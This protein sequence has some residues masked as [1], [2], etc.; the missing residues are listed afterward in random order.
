MINP[1]ITRSVSILSILIQVCALGFLCPLVSSSSPL[2]SPSPRD[3][4][5]QGR[6]AFVS[7]RSG[8]N[9]IY[10]MRP[11][12]TD[13]VNLT[14]HPA[15]DRLP[16]WSPDGSKIAFR[17]T[18]NGNSEIYVMNDDGSGVIRLTFDPA[19]D[20]SPAWT[21]EG[22]VLFSSNR[23]GRF[24]IYSVK[25][26]GSDLRHID[27]AVDGDLTF[28][29]AS[30]SG[31][32]LAFATT[33]FFDTGAIWI[34]HPDGSHEKQLTDDELVAAFPDWSPTGNRVVFSNNVCPV[35]DL[36]EI[37]VVNQGGNNLRQLT[38]SGD[39]F[40]DLFPRWS[41]DGTQI[42]FSRDD[43]VEATEIY[44]MNADGTGVTNIT[45]HPSFDFE[46][47]WGP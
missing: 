8:N 38:P 40:N 34:A 32:R 28:P 6:I 43:F 19:V 44:I 27:I 21:P 22:L 33:N 45:Q 39:G 29:S 31:H 30:A 12:G 17:S 9:D 5:A 42:V 10:V 20:T 46:A 13:L 7:N 11:D 15:S 26:D 35:C 4:N 37:M 41:P 1:S 16:A 23:S 18:R 3:H 25:P 36:S 24:E 2:L 47:D 14:H